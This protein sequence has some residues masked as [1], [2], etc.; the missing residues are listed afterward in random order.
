VICGYFLVTPRILHKIVKLGDK[1]SECPLPKMSGSVTS[2]HGEC[3]TGS[4][5]GDGSRCVVV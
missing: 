5:S 1:T 2:L 4:G 3:G